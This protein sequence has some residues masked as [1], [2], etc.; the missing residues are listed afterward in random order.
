MLSPVV[1]LVSGERFATWTGVI[2]ELIALPFR[3][4]FGSLL[5]FSAGNL[6]RFAAI[7]RALDDLPE[8]SAGLRC[9][10]AVRVHGRTLQVIHLPS[11]EVRAV[12]I[13]LLAL[14]IR[15]Q[16]ECA[17]FCSYENSY[18]AHAFSSSRFRQAG[19]YKL[20]EGSCGNVDVRW[21]RPHIVA[22]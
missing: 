15:R 7:I 8:P 1:P 4:T 11:P 6:P 20:F 18:T 13:P 5:G 19:K 12:H 10:D 16:N 2:G 14:A 17:L 21:P 3:H 9:V 22:R